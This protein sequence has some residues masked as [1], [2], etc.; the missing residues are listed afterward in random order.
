MHKEQGGLARRPFQTL[1]ITNQGRACQKHKSKT[2]FWAILTKISKLQN[3]GSKS[4]FPRIYF[5]ISFKITQW[6]I[7]HSFLLQFSPVLQQLQLLEYPTIFSKLWLPFQTN[8]FQVAIQ[9]TVTKGHRHAAKLKT[10][11]GS[12]FTYSSCYFTWKSSFS[13]IPRSKWVRVILWILLTSWSSL[14]VLTALTKPLTPLKTFNPCSVKRNKSFTSIWEK[15]LICK[16]GISENNKMKNWAP[17]LCMLGLTNSQE[18][19]ISF[20]SSVVNTPILSKNC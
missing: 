3:S 12:I 10:L 7:D 16:W 18:L 9:G 13:M 1:P 6:F 17:C 14:S 8:D 20:R 5:P 11:W 2:C 4:P 19:T 15:C